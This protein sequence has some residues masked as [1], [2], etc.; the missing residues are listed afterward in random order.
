VSLGGRRVG[1]TGQQH[2]TRADAARG[3]HA[4]GHADQE[5]ATP[6]RL[7]AEAGRDPDLTGLGPAQQAT[8]TARLAVLEGITVSRAQAGGPVH[9]T[10]RCLEAVGRR[11]FPV[12]ENE[13]DKR[14]VGGR[15]HASATR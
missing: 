8:D 4:G 15:R 2:R 5:T 13:I 12:G 14:R 1:R 10:R 6:Y 7:V 3:H 11:L 9:V